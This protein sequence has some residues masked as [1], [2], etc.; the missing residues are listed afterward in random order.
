MWEVSGTGGDTHDIV[1]RF[2]PHTRREAERVIDRE[3]RVRDAEA[4]PLDAL[5]DA[6]EA[7]EQ[8]GPATSVRG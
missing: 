6:L 7:M 5:L 1:L 2:G 8:R 4:D 3:V